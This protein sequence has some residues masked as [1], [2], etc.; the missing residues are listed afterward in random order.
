MQLNNKPLHYI[1]KKSE[2]IS[3]TKQKCIKSILDIDHNNIIIDS[4][5]LAENSKSYILRFH[6]YV[7]ENTEIKFS[8][9]KNINKIIE[10]D[11]MENDIEIL[12][13]SNELKINIKPFEI[14][15]LKIFFE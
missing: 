9:N 1:S 7:G 6:E 8:F 4:F 5:K 2:N 12:T 10:T 14:K 13:K 3:E 15:T 11:L